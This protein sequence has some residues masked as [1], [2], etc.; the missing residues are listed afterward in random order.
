MDFFYLGSLSLIIPYH[1]LISKVCISETLLFY[2]FV[3]PSPYLLRGMDLNSFYFRNLLPIFL[4]GMDLNSFHFRNLIPIFLWG[5]DLNS[6]YFR[7]LLPI[8]L[9]GM[10]L[11]SFHFRNLLPIFCGVWISTV[12]I[13]ETFSLFFCEYGF[14]LRNIFLCG[15]DLNISW[16]STVFISETFSLFFL[17]GMDLNSFYFRNLPYFFCGVWIS[18]VLFR[19]PIIP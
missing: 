3:R 13:S 7:N 10:D 8:F 4:C 15:M 19:G 5:M 18:T 16:I 11:N 1:T 6:F 9:C 12:F 2:F 17:W 14:H